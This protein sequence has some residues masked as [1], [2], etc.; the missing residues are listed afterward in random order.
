M[1]W[2]AARRRGVQRLVW[3]LVWFGG[4]TGACMHACPRG[5]GQN[6]VVEMLLAAHVSMN[7]W[8]LRKPADVCKHT[9]RAARWDPGASQ[10]S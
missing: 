7:A 8:W 2:R 10:L 9:A 5:R 4:G 6:G 3:G 1:R